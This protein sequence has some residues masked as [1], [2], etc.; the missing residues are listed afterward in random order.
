[1]PSQSKPSIMFQEEEKI[2]PVQKT[3]GKLKVKQEGFL[4]PEVKMMMTMMMMT[5]MTIM[6]CGQKFVF[7]I[8]FCMGEIEDLFMY[9]AWNRD[10][11]FSFLQLSPRCKPVSNTA[12]AAVLNLL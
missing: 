6:L 8:K 7:Q 3:D 11:G 10:E 5:T 12:F 2:L 4:L 1:M 9:F